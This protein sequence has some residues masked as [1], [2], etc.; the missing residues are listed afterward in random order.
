M[1]SV[2]GRAILDTDGPITFRKRRTVLKL[3]QGFIGCRYQLIV[4]CVQRGF[5][6]VLQS[7]VHREAKSA[8]EPPIGPVP[9]SS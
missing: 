8:P 6:R 7:L 4:F 3:S 2:S 9:S 1:R 5:E